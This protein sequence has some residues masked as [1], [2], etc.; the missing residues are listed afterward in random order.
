VDE[1]EEAIL[2][3]WL[4]CVVVDDGAGALE[5]D[6]ELEELVLQAVKQ[7]NA[8]PTTQETRTKRKTEEVD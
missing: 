5:E 1:L 7:S 4:A 3:V 2:I 6:V 8:M